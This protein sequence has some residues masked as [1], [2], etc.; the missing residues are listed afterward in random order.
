MKLY[1]LRHA[2]AE[3]GGTVSDHERRLTSK[4]MQQAK[5]VARALAVLGVEPAR[6]Y[7][8]PRV[9]ARQT[10]ETVAHVLELQVEIREELNFGFNLEALRSLLDRTSENVD[11]M[12]VGHEPTFSAT[13]QD[14]TGAAVQMKKCGLARIDLTHRSALKGEL[15]WLIP[16]KIF[17]AADE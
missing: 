8:S 1:F 2:H 6:I 5:I 17:K 15:V 16:P 12:L 10:A 3:D 11:I 9:R 7:S 4:G 14:L 13:I